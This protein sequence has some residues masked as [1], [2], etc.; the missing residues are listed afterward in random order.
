[1]ANEI[2]KK[3]IFWWFGAEHGHTASRETSIP[4]T[5]TVTDEGKIR[6][7]LEGALWLESPRTGFGWDESRWLPMDVRIAGCLGD[8]GGDG[9]VLLF[10]LLRTDF[11]LPD[12]TPIRQSYEAQMCFKS[13]SAFSTDFDLDH[14]HTLRIELQG[15]EEWL[16]LESIDVGYECREGDRTEFTVSYNNHEFEYQTERAKVTVENLILGAPVIRLSEALTS[17]VHIRQTNWLVYTPTDQS[18]FS[19]L[20]TAY[21]RIEEVIALFLGRY[22][23]LDWPQF[24]AKYGEF[25]DWYT[26][27]FPRGPKSEKLTNFYFFWTIFHSVRDRFGDLLSRWQTNTE[28]Y[29]AA[30]ELY[31]ASMQA[32]LPHT[33]HQFVNLVWAVESL[34]RSW[35]R[36][37][38]EP[39]YVARRKKRIEAVLGRFDEATDKKLRDWLK[40]KL[41]Y[42]YEPTLQERI[43]EVFQRLPFDLDSAQLQS[44]AARCA[45]RRNGISHEGGRES[46]ESA[47]TF[48]SD[49]Q[50][51]AEALKYLFH[52]LLLHEIGLSSELL[53][54]A[55]TEGGLAERDVLPCLR[56]ISLNLL[57]TTAKSSEIIPGAIESGE[58]SP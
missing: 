48:R 57:K 1:M 33:E 23:R 32:P 30:Y 7:Q 50:E 45:K 3:G 44:F 34:H 16:R 6:L 17:E 4:G 24:V 56:R 13:D 40:G 14:F 52:A 41:R 28:K 2:E 55:M 39:A 51:L 53:I 19:E 20:R 22:F 12:D 18:L 36:E 37:N 26:L 54:R 58:C 47:E 5:L 38:E 29:G 8:Y 49:I 35:Q 46:D 31:M 15:L 21:S 9:Y 42:A 11:S 43:V 10:D 27:Y 25:D